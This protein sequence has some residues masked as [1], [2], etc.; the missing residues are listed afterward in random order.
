MDRII[1]YQ[2]TTRVDD[3]VKQIAD[4]AGKGE[5]GEKQKKIKDNIFKSKRELIE[6]YFLKKVSMSFV[7]LIAFASITMLLYSSRYLDGMWTLLYSLSHCLL[8][9]SSFLF[10]AR[11]INFILYLVSDSFYTDLIAK[12]DKNSTSL[13]GIPIGLDCLTFSYVN[14][15]GYRVPII[16]SLDEKETTSEEIAFDESIE[17]DDIHLNREEAKQLTDAQEKSIYRQSIIILNTALRQ[18]KINETKAK[19]GQHCV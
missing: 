11:S 15:A 16:Y 9:I 12:K 17:I 6:E 10:G 19:Y 13:N 8:I 1:T 4:V 5:D 3:I 14:E 7:Y 2:P 18:A